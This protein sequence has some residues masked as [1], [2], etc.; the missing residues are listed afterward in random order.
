MSYTYPP[1]PD[2]PSFSPAALRRYL[3]GNSALLRDQLRDVLSEPEFTPVTAGETLT[4]ARERTLR[5]CRGLVARDCRGLFSPPGSGDGSDPAGFFDATEILGSHDLSLFTKFGVQIGLWG[6]SVLHLGTAPHHAKYL[7]ATMKF[8]LPGCFAMTE[9]GHGSNVRD[10]ETTATY[11]D[12]TETF[13]IH[14]PTLSSGKSYIGNAAL[15]GRIATVFAQLQIAGQRLGVHAFV[16]PIRDAAGRLLPG[17]R[18]EDNG[19][20]MGLNGVD[21]GKIW[22]DHVRIPRSDLLDKFAQVAPDGTY[23]SKI[24]NPGARFFAM[25]ATLVGGRIAVGSAAAAAAKTGLTIA[26]RYAARRRQFGKPGESEILLLDYPTH[27]ARLF[28]HLAATYAIWFGRAELVRRYVNRDGDGRMLETLAAGF[29]AWATD[30]ATTTLQRCREACGGEGFMSINRIGGLKADSDIF[31][32][33]EG[34]NTVLRQ[35]AAKNL[36]GELQAELKQ[37]GGASRLAREQARGWLG[38]RTAPARWVHG[39]AAQAGWQRAVLAQR[40]RLALIELGQAIR[41]AKRKG[42]DTTDAFLACQLEAIQAVDAWIESFLYDCF[43]AGVRACPDAM[44]RVA[45]TDLCTLFAL[46]RIQAASGWLGARGFMGARQLRR[47]STEA[48]RLRRA[49]RREAVGLVDAFGLTPEM[50]G[51]PIALDAAAS[52]AHEPT[53]PAEQPSLATR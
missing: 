53:V 44:A 26:I 14:S 31:T 36:L 32:T 27:Q 3:E 30:H 45:L 28:P 17:I 23:T 33:F 42:V 1:I 47:V 35:L 15:H 8:E 48:A 12:A 43:A 13:T 20:K 37:P 40:A 6:G 5:W 46:D 4:E 11:D 49:I 24:E 39:E 22:F 7:P 18:I 41:A 21:N 10:I 2:R 29:K 25:V 19:H 16:V 34:D 9:L 52:V 50:I 38:W 51:A